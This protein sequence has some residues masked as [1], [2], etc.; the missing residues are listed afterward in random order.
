MQDLVVV[1]NLNGSA[2]RM[3]A[4]KLRAEHIYYRIVSSACAAEDIQRMGARGIVLA[5]GVSGE[6]ADVPFLMDYLLTGLPMLCVGD[7]ALSLCQTLGG[8]LSEPVPQDGAMQIHLDAS[9]ALLDGMED[10]DR[11]Q[12]TARF[13]SLDGAQAT[14]IATTDG[15]MLGFPASRRDV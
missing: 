3:M 8:E 2:C 13:M 10:T 12:P 11:Y 4:Q 5:A 6:A 14:P 9:D 15:G 1:V 7:S